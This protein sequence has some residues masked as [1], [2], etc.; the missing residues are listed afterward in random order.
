MILMEFLTIMH[1][2]CFSLTRDI[3]PQAISSR[4]S[5]FTLHIKPKLFLLPKIFVAILA[6]FGEQIKVDFTQK[7]S[8]EFKTT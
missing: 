1:M 2:T 3:N 6:I 8:E 4:I 7:R 5:R